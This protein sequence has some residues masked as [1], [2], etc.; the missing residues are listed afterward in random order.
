MSHVT[1]DGTITLG[2]KTNGFAKRILF[3]GQS[4]LEPL[5]ESMQ[6]E[7]SVLFLLALFS[8]IHLVNEIMETTITNLSGVSIQSVR[9]MVT[10]FW[11]HKPHNE[12]MG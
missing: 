10:S 8:S 4:R 11:G 1:L 2:L 9:P 5:W 6:S 3:G 12:T 7:R